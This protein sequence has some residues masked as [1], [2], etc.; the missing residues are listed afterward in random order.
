MRPFMPV[1]V[2]PPMT[3]RSIL[4][5]PMVMMGAILY[6][7]VALGLGGLSLAMLGTGASDDF[8]LAPELSR[9]GAYEADLEM[10]PEP[11]VV[12]LASP[13][14]ARAAYDGPGRTSY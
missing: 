5:V 14:E 6:W 7:T 12:R 4:W 8:E 10:L 9:Q 11:I 2:R 13:D 1:E 3:R